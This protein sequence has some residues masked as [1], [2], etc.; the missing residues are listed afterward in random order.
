VHV[1]PGRDICAADGNLF[2]KPQEIDLAPI[3]LATGYDQVRFIIGWHWH[4]KWVG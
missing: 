1:V 2:T 3:N 4:M